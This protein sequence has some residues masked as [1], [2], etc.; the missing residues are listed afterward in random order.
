MP[1]AVEL[2]NGSPHTHSDRYGEVVELA[3]LVDEVVDE[4]EAGSGDNASGSRRGAD[5]DSDYSSDDGDDW[6]ETSIALDLC[7]P[8]AGDAWAQPALG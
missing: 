2:N 4:P 8:R 5:D 1:V 6:L 7:D 3:G